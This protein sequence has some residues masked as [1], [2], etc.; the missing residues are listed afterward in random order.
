MADSIPILTEPHAPSAPEGVGR[1]VEP[2]A[3]LLVGGVFGTIGFALS[4]LWLGAVV[5]IEIALVAATIAFVQRARGPALN[6]VAAGAL[7]AIALLPSTIAIIAAALCFAN[8]LMLAA[9]RPA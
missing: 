6:F 7:C 2:L 5:G 8:G 3:A 4:A 1:E 9:R